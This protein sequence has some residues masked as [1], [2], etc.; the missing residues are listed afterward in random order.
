MSTYD[1][2]TVL[3]DQINDI[4]QKFKLVVNKLR[5]KRKQM[6]IKNSTEGYWLRL[7]LKSNLFLLFERNPFS[8]QR[9]PLLHLAFDLSFKIKMY[10]KC[11]F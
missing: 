9:E 7:K 3:I 10:A 6:L 4:I 8:V 2:K 1:C 11:M 5:K